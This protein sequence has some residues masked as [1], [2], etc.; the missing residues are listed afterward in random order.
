MEQLGLFDPQPRARRKDPTTSHVA[1]HK[2]RTVA[3]NHRNLI[4]AKLTEPMNAYDIAR[5]TGLTQVQVCR[6]MPELDELKLAH[7]TTEHRDGIRLWARTEN[8][9]L[10]P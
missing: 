6:R 7:P 3:P 2:A 1:A 8:H 4:M 10:T 9:A 5:A